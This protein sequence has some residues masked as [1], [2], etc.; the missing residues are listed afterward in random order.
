M[1]KIFLPLLALVAMASC[2]ETSLTTGHEFGGDAADPGAPIKAKTTTRALTRTPYE[3]SDIAAHNVLANVIAYRC[4][5]GDEDTPDF[6]TAPFCNSFMN[7]QD[8]TTPWPYIPTAQFYPPVRTCAALH[9]VGLYPATTSTDPVSTSTPLDIWTLDTD[10]AN[11]NNGKVSATFDGSRD[12]M[13]TL[14]VKTVKADA[15]GGYQ[16]I[17]FNHLLTK[18]ILQIKGI[19]ARWGKIKNVEIYAAGADKDAGLRGKA[20]VNLPQTVGQGVAFCSTNVAFDATSAT[21]PAKPELFT[22]EDNSDAATATQVPF[23]YNND[24]LL[25]GG[26]IPNGMALTEDYKTF[27]YTMVE[28]IN[29]NN[30]HYYIKVVTEK[31]E[32]D[33]DGSMGPHIYILEVTDLYTT[34]DDGNGGFT[35]FQGETMGWQ[36]VVQ[37]NCSG[38]EIKAIAKVTPWQEGGNSSV[39]IDDDNVTN[40]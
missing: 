10:A 19:E 17:T 20:T 33:K 40:N 22:A 16:R 34:D 3:G 5:S 38:T 36:F 12:L 7:F 2:T 9:L 39:D 8:N 31:T 11:T 30:Q 32:D 27:A 15:Q 21:A 26:E 35:K 37:I 24:K 28:P 18:L 14:P 13:A 4:Q 29:A 6:I 25:T 1:K 23:I